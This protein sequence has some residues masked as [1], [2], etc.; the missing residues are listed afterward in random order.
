MVDLMSEKHFTD[1]EMCTVASFFWENISDE[2]KNRWKKKSKTLKSNDIKVAPFWLF[3]RKIK[4]SLFFKNWSYFEFIWPEINIEAK[5]L[6]AKL[7]EKKKE[8]KY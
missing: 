8:E 3:S 7:M 5:E 2:Y 6:W 4:S 1:K